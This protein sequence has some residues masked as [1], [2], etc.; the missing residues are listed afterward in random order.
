MANRTEAQTRKWQ[1]EM[2]IKRLVK[3]DEDLV[4]IISASFDYSC[5]HEFLSAVSTLSQAKSNEITRVIRQ[6]HNEFQNRMDFIAE[7]ASNLQMTSISSMQQHQKL[8][9]GSERGLDLGSSPAFQLAQTTGEELINLREQ[10]AQVELALKWQAKQ[11]QI[12]ELVAQGEFSKAHEVYLQLQLELDKR[13]VFAQKLAVPNVADVC[14]QKVLREWM[15]M[16]MDL[17]KLAGEMLCQTRPITGSSST[18]PKVETASVLHFANRNRANKQTYKKQRLVLFR[19]L[20]RLQDALGFVWLEEQ[21]GLFSLGERRELWQTLEERFAFAQLASSHEEPF[22]FASFLVHV[23]K[24]TC[25]PRLVMRYGME[26]D[27]IQSYAFAKLDHFCLQRLE[28]L[29]AASDIATELKLVDQELQSVLQWLGI[30]RPKPNTIQVLADCITGKLAGHQMDVTKIIHLFDLCQS[31][32]LVETENEVREHLQHV[33]ISSQLAPVVLGGATLPSL[34]ETKIDAHP[35]ITKWIKQL[36]ISQQQL[37][38]QVQTLIVS[39][40]VTKLIDRIELVLFGTP[41][42]RFNPLLLKQFLLDVR[43]IA[44]HH[45]AHEQLEDLGNILQLFCQDH[46]L[47]AFCSQSPIDIELK[48][49]N[50]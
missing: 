17:G 8:N 1:A 50:E 47:E 38:R 26:W 45:P 27:K 24:I 2:L 12:G 5:E 30:N 15:P 41:H 28:T 25:S 46:A 22:Q 23:P 7:Q 29:T 3:F 21:V 18:L 40:T 44:L 13:S 39:Q 14:E 11:R 20:K 33:F 37:P 48:T 49:P 31:F 19:Q 35:S 36:E 4:N 16:A 9:T 43:L 34:M 6:N 32:H 42:Q 10:I